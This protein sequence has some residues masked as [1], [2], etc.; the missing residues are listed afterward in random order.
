MDKPCRD[1]SKHGC[2]AFLK[3]PCPPR[4][5]GP[6]G[7]PIWEDLAGKVFPNWQHVS[8]NLPPP[9]N[10]VPQNPTPSFRDYTLSNLKGFCNKRNAA[11]KPCQQLGILKFP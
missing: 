10:L 8:L 7:M 1:G 9:F 11:N 5:C 2:A 4:A 6:A 3:F